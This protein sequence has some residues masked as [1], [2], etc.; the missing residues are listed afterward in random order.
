[1][2]HEVGAL[3]RQASRHVNMR[4]IGDAGKAVMANRTVLLLS[5]TPSNTC[6]TQFTTLWYCF[7][8]SHFLY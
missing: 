2:K 7:P 3:R 4:A 5:Q 1:M 6:F 8:L